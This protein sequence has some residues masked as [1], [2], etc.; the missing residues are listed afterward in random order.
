[1]NV[2]CH[3]VG[4]NCMSIDLSQCCGMSD[5]AGCAMMQDVVFCMCRAIIDSANIESY[6]LTDCIRQAIR[7]AKQADPEK[8][9]QLVSQAKVGRSQGSQSIQHRQKISAATFG[10]TRVF[11]SI[12]DR[13]ALV[14]KLRHLIHED[15]MPAQAAAMQVC[16]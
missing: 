2:A 11:R 10:R 3:V 16:F 5:H 15:K 7:A 14:D 13:D 8:S 4:G 1:M 6:K 9:K 12:K